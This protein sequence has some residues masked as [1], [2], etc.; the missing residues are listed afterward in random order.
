MPRRSRE[1]VEGAIYHVYN[2]FA[3]GAD[4]F[5]DRRE[6]ERFLDL[7]VETRGRDGLT[8]LAWCLMS[9]HYH[10]VVRVGTVSLG[11]SLGIAQARF[12]QCLNRRSRSSGPLWQS[13]YK[14][15]RVT[16]ERHLF[17]LIAYVHLNPVTA[18]LVAD[19]TEYPLSGHGELLGR[20]KARLI[21]VDGTL[22]LFDTTRAAAR[23]SYLAAVKG[24]RQAEWV[25]EGP[26]RLPWW[27]RETDAP[28]EA[29]PAAP[30]LDPLGRSLG[31]ERPRFDGATFIERACEALEASPESLSSALKG[32]DISEVRYLVGGLAIERWR[33]RAG[34]LAAVLG[35]R[36]E[37]ITRWAAQAGKRKQT[38][39]AFRRRYEEL[40]EVLYDPIRRTRHRRCSS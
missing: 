38:H 8:I 15:K 24:D 25:G 28:I 5:S 6:A 21:D 36:P 33:L 26:G 9:N 12:G 13:R 2:R 16:D 23:R 14:A 4:V 35:K 22:A 37:V 32:R 19:P 29:E 18:G 20:R 39:E 31:P 1:F 3:H 7:L 11:R 10:L 30:R 17:Q 27:R 40:D 34:E